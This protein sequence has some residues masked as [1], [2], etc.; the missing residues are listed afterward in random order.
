MPV[1]FE[2]L[3]PVFAHSSSYVAAGIGLEA[4]YSQSAILACTELAHISIPHLGPTDDKMP[5]FIAIPGL[6]SCGWR[7]VWSG[8]L[9]LRTLE[10]WP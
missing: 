3:A 1:S 8:T 5:A 9:S 10:S 7:G 6:R 2:T 4:Q